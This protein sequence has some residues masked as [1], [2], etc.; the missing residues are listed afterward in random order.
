M[1]RVV[2]TGFF[3]CVVA[4]LV[5]GCGT[6]SPV[7]HYGLVAVETS[8][9]FPVSDEFAISVGPFR[10]AEYLNRSQI[11]TRGDG[12]K[13][14]R[15]EFDLWAE[16]LLKSFQR[17][18]ADN[19]AVLLDSDR[20]LDFP[21]YAELTAGYQLPGQVT[22]FDTDPGGLAVLEIQWM[23]KDI[24]DNRIVPARRSRYTGQVASPGEYSSVVEA[25][26]ELI[27]SFSR[28]VAATLAELP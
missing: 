11:V 1:I 7:R 17:A 14:N 26:S 24:D 15:A 5:S 10:I 25:L 19:L 20:V 4:V 27:G 21:A 6:S 22:R 3:A 28:D 8:V 18:V 13:M 23:V 2:H 16:P 12:V 9:Q